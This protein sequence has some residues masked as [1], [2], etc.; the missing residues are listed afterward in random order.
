MLDGLAGCVGLVGVVLRFVPAPGEDRC[1]EHRGDQGGECASV[2]PSG[3]VDD[4]AGRAPQGVRGAGFGSDLGA[5]GACERL[6]S[7]AQLVA[8]VGGSLLGCGFDEFTERDGLAL[9]LGVRP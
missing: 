4:V 6:A 3:G 2:G 1:P 7:G 9:C 8:E 5:L